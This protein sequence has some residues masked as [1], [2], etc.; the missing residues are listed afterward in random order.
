MTTILGYIWCFLQDMLYIFVDI[1][2]GHWD[3]LLAVT[4][5]MLTTLGGNPWTFSAIP[6]QYA[7]LLGAT[8]M[9]EALT[10]VATA[11]GVRFFMQSVPF[12]RWGS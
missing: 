1:A 10:I 9:G 4:D 3:S 12:V 11:L 8:G 2:L 7:W 6:T 5:S